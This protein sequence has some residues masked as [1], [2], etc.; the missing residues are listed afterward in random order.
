[1]AT[2]IEDRLAALERLQ[3]ERRQ[4]QAGTGAGAVSPE[5]ARRLYEEFMAPA[6]PSQSPSPFAGLDPVEAARL[7]QHLIG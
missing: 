6:A 2:R 5:D 4:A 7:Y 3:Q 1:M